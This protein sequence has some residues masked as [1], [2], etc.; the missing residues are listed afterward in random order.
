M[1]TDNNPRGAHC[2]AD[3]LQFAFISHSNMSERKMKTNAL[4]TDK[5]G[6]AE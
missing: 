6:D 2:P 4:L 1:M 5:V 3:R